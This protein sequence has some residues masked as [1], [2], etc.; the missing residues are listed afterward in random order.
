M[1]ARTALVWGESDRLID[2]AYATAWQQLLPAARL[3]RVPGAGHMV[4]YEKPE[5]VVA[6]IG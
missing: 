5:A 6:A 4:P 1:R 3:V 2:P